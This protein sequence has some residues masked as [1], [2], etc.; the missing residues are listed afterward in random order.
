MALGLSKPHSQIIELDGLSEQQGLALAVESAK[1]LGWQISY[2]S[3]A[4]MRAFTNFGDNAWNATV[5]FLPTPGTAKV[6]STSFT[7][8]F[9]DA[10]KNKQ[11][12]ALFLSAFSELKASLTPQ[13]LDLRYEELK[14]S[15]P[16]P[17]DLRD[18][19]RLGEEENDGTL[20]SLFIPRKNYFITPVLVNLNIAV[21]LLMVLTGVNALLPSVEDL[22][23]WGANFRPT[24]LAGESW[25]LFTCCFLH[26]GIL[27]L[28]MNM[29]AL[30]YIGL[31]LEPI[32]GRGRFLAAYIL[33]GVLSSTASLWWN[34]LTVSAGASGAIFGM[35]GVFLAL[36]TTNVVPKNIRGPLLSS[37]GI[38]VGY[39]LIFGMKGGIDNAAHIG[40]LLSGLVMGYAFYPALIR[41]EAKNLN[42]VTLGSLT[43]LT[44]LTIWLVTG[45]TSNDVGKYEKRM[46][47]FTSLE[48]EAI[49]IYQMPENT[50]TDALLAE[51][52]DHGIANW[53]K[54]FALVTELDKLD[55]PAEIHHRNTLLEKYCELRLKAYELIYKAIKE[56]SGTYQAEIEGYNKQ[57]EAIINEISGTNKA[58]K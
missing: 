17:E 56:N 8:G 24:T 51:V 37:I 48:A 22:L 26:I 46:S 53:K 30:V 5:K 57:I 25:R 10:K 15:F 18:K 40:G 58:G 13:E 47:E 14:N 32:L 23:K 3:A 36:L 2:V 1:K 4:G 20:L 39:N 52:Q 33:T 41:P 42:Q 55:L 34:E 12:L 9:S 7:S 50:P 38:F 29:Y 28:L 54:A 35:Y 6:S 43:I 44:A 19:E 27:H 45:N 31:L 49:K 16:A 11:N 21:F